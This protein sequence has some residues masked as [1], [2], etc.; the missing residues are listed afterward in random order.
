[1]TRFHSEE[2]RSKDYDA[3]DWVAGL[4][5][6]DGYSL[7]HYKTFTPSARRALQA[8]AA[9]G[10]PLLVSGS[11]IGRDM[12]ADAERQFLASVLRCQ[13]AGS[14]ACASDTVAGLG[15]T[16]T[17]HRALNERHYAAPHPDN[18]SPAPGAFAAMRYADGHD[19]AVAC[20]GQAARTLAVGFPLE[21]I[22]EK[23]K[24]SSLIRGM[25]AFITEK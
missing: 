25:M 21:C 20:K 10:G 2:P 3:V 5:R 16:A 6:N 12:G 11:Y 7:G 4:E 15:T 18:L 1:M 13:W 17:F 24:R 9:G 19:A 23:A 22:K 14:N 8:Y